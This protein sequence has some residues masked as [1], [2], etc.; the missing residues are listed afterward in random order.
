MFKGGKSNYRP[1]SVLPS[2]SKI[3]VF[4]EF[5][6][7]S[8]CQRN[9]SNSTALICLRQKLFYCNCIDQN[10]PFMETG[11]RQTG[12]VYMRF[13]WL[14][15][16]HATLLDKL[17]EYGKCGTGMEWII[18][19]SISEQACLALCRL[20]AAWYLCL[21]SYHTKTHG[22]IH[23]SL[24]IIVKFLLNITTLKIQSDCFGIKCSRKRPTDCSL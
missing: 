11:Y 22:I 14:A 13:S 21:G 16:D 24:Y 19:F 2:I 9:R 15:I 7:T 6:A 8:L 3:Q 18:F 20:H 17:Q 1:I 12:E 4:H 5:G 10:S 23:R